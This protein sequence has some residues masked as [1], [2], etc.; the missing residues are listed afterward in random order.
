MKMDKLLLQ[1]WQLWPIHVHNCDKPISDLVVLHVLCYDH[2]E[3][4]VALQHA[5]ANARN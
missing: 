2:Q 3:T 1:P 4:G 5:A